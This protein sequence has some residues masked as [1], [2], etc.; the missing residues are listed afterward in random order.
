M[1]HL[2]KIFVIAALI[3]LPSHL[4][5]ADSAA[6][7]A[8]PRLVPGPDDGRIAYVTTRLLEMN[9]YLQQPLDAEMSKKFFDGYL[10]ALDP[11]RENFLQSDVDEFAHYRTNLDQFMINN[12]ETSDLTPAFEIYQRFLERLTQHDAYVAE[13]LKEDKF[14]FTGDD[15]LAIDRRHAPYPKD[16]DEAKELWREQLRYQYLQEKLGRELSATNDE[17][18]SLTKSNLMDINDTFARH[19]RWNYHMATNWDSSD[20]LQQYLE[21][22]AHAYDP[23]SDYFS[24]PHAQDFSIQMN[25]SLFGIGARLNEDDGYCTILELVPGGPAAKSKLVAEQDRILAVAQANRPAVNV[26]DMDLEKVVQLIR[27]AKGTPVQLTIS[28]ASDRAARHIV[29]LT[30]DEIKLEDSEAKAKLIELPDGHGGTKRIGVIDLPSF[31]APMDPSAGPQHSKQSYTSVDVAKLIKKLK[32]EKVDGIVLDLRNNPGGSLE[33]AVR[34][35][36][37]FIKDGPVVLTR[38]PNG[39]VSVDSDPDPSVLY[40]GP[41]A[42]MIN[43]FSASAAEIAAAALQDYGRAVIVGDKSTHGK[44][45]VQSLESLRPIMVSSLTD[46]GQLKITIRKFYRVTGASTQLK[47]VVPDIILPDYLNYSDDVGETSLDNPL[48]WDT[49]P[50][51]D[52]NKLNLNY[53]KLNLVDPYVAAL[54]QNSDARIATN[55]DFIYINQDIEQYKKLEADKTV[56]LNEREEIQERET[57]QARQKVRE[58]EQ[59]AR[60]PSNS[61]IY[62][63]TVENAE[64]PGLPEPMAMTVT[65]FAAGSTIGN[66]VTYWASNSNFA[67]YFGTNNTLA[68][69]NYIFTNNLVSGN[70]STNRIEKPTVKNVLPLDPTLNETLN[71][72]EDYIAALSS[73]H[74]VVVQ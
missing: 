9:H 3:T 24:A 38:S 47:G 65:N 2:I 70:S 66:G 59:Q 68:L 29:T 33:E 54:R 14:K 46:P 6:T 12:H 39:D 35:T 19:F 8:S 57:N 43:R 11:R 27:G 51:A 44:G 17:V 61:K 32:Q 55:Q 48:P 71:I 21:A 16:L 53:D 40:D 56:S 4:L 45:T 36:G 1:R 25:L 34:L 22:L 18:F 26:V 23:H 69:N 73:A 20:V 52:Y 58:Q 62:E 30:R 49:I 28:P 41:L 5:L 13:V 72:L 7:N 63:L 64:L 42:V 60:K 15:R 67:S 10:A 31:Y 37:L 50:S 74:T